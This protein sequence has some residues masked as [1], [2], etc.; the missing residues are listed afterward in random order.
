MR[1]SF[2]ARIA[3][4]QSKSKSPHHI[5]HHYDLDASFYMDFLDPYN[6]YSCG[7]F[8]DTTDLAIAQQQKLDLICRKLHLSKDDY[9][10]D[11]GCGR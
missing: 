6:Q 4:K 5:A 2:T 8:K 11:I 1:E 9:V 10:L 3:N 7:Y